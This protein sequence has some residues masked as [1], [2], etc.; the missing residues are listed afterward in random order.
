MKFIFLSIL[1]G[2]DHYG[3]VVTTKRGGRWLVH[4]GFNFSRLSHTVV[5]SANHMSKRWMVVR[6]GKVRNA[7]VTDFIT[8]GGKFFHPFYD[9]AFHAAT[10]MMKLTKKE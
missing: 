8:A 4:K 6:K 2:Y 7:V 3:V 9:N 10:R 1:T 5:T